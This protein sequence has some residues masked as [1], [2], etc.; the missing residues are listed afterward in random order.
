[1]TELKIILVILVLLI[2]I[3]VVGIA[4]FHFIIFDFIRFGDEKNKVIDFPSEIEYN[5]ER[6]EEENG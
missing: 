2:L 6:K 3:A 4:K 1:M 5:K